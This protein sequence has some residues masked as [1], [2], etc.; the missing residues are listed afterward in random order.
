MPSNFDF[1]RTS[2]PEF[3]ESATEAERS[4]HPSPRGACVVARYCLE[5]AVIW[6]YD[7]DRD[8]RRPLG[9]KLAD[10]DLRAAS[11]RTSRPASTRVQL[12]HKLGN[13]AAHRNQRLT[14]TD[15]QRSV[16]ALHA[17][18]FWLAK[19]YGKRRPP[20]P[21]PVF[22]PELLARPAG[23]GV[24]LTPEQLA[25]LEKK[26]ADRD[27]ELAA[28][29]QSLTAELARA[30][31]REKELKSSPR[32]SAAAQA[33]L[34]EREQKLGDN[35]VALD[36]AERA[37]QAKAAEL[38]PRG[39]ARRRPRRGRGPAR[40]PR[41]RAQAVATVRAQRVA[42]DPL[43]F[44]EAE[45]RA[46]LIDTAARGRLA[47]RQTRS[48]GGPRQARRRQHPAAPTTCS[49]RHDGRPLAV[50]EAKKT[51]ATP[52]AARP[53][54]SATPTRSSASTAAAR[55]SSTTNG[56]KIFLWDDAR[57]YP[58]RDHRRLLH[59]RRGRDPD[60]PPARSAR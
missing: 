17:F 8:L 3:H 35:V 50:I 28:S 36:A 29:R 9:D 49:G 7:H 30:E 47:R 13:A 56:H 11:S 4:V 15:A 54:P 16:A 45:T 60:R 38:G 12:V 57:G 59:A 42:A 48:T 26:L 6:L 37:A 34:R 20:L 32:T 14:A 10:P 19:F 44:D 21:P 33:E 5:Q 22:R 24:D 31:A 51:S 46:Q 55:S 23:K 52:S 58:P 2:R 1:L 25:A 43:T 27:A 53:R 41:G 18:L 39:R 40:P